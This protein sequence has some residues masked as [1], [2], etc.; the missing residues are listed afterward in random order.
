[1]IGVSLV[2]I[3]KQLKQFGK[4]CS[5]I[6]KTTFIGSGTMFLHS[7]IL[8]QEEKDLLKKAFFS[9]QK[10]CFDRIGT[11]PNSDKSIINEIADK[12]HLKY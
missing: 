11:L 8:T 3:L 12:L 4:I 1:M 5:I 6:S 7:A 9:Y 10:E 2:L